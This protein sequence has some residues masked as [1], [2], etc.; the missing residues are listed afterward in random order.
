VWPDLV[1]LAGGTAGLVGRAERHTDEGRPLLALHLTDV[2]LS[3]SP[4]DPDA[5]RVKRAAL[6][7]LEATAGGENFSEMQW[8]QQEI[9]STTTD[10]ETV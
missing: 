5:S 10:E 9:N 7:Q 6:Q 4:K 2:V 1:E 3:H 8:L